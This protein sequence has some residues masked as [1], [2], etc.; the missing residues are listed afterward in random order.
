MRD[1]HGKKVLE[2]D[3]KVVKDDKGKKVTTIEE[4][5]KVIEGDADVALV[6]MWQFFVRK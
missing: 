4:I 1:F 2:F 6:A 3:G 5:Q